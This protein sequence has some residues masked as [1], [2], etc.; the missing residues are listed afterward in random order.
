M[1]TESG[2]SAWL[3]TKVWTTV[4]A[5][6]GGLSLV[7][8]WTPAKLVEKGKVVSIFL[9]GALSAAF[10]FA[11][12]GLVATRFGIDPMQLDYIVGIAWLLGF[13]ST[14]IF[15]WI[16]NFISKRSDADIL[17]VYVDVKNKT[18]RSGQQPNNK[19]VRK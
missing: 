7:L 5:L 17:D 3:V 4:A 16:A 6:F 13:A 8:F 19:R 15:N 1:I 9:A 2:I 10:G 14:A 12:T 18:T 11:L